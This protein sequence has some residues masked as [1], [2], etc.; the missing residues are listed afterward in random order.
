MWLII[1]E[2][3]EP[4]KDVKIIEAGSRWLKLNWTMDYAGDTNYI[5][6]YRPMHESVW[7]NFTLPKSNSNYKVETLLPNTLY[8]LKVIA[9]NEIGK[10][11]ASIE[12]TAKTLQEG[13]VLFGSS[14]QYWPRYIIDSIR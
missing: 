12:V 7:Y 10:S 2:P 6:Q 9:V 14:L 3:P 4:P 8:L 13:K 5:I 11:K 1:L